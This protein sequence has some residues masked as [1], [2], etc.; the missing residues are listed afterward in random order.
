MPTTR[1]VS[2]AVL[3]AAAGTLIVP[4]AAQADDYCVNRAGC[5]P[6]NTFGPSIQAGLDAA[7]AH[8]NSGG[9]DRVLIGPGTYGVT[10]PTLTYSGDRVEVTGAGQG[11]GG[12][13][14]TGSAGDFRTLLSVTGPEP[15]R[16]SRLALEVPRGVANTGLAITGTAE[17]IAVTGGSGSTG[18]SGV[19]SATVADS[20]VQMPTE[21]SSFF[22]TVA[23]YADAQDLTVTDSVVEG[24]YGVSS[25]SGETVVQRTH[26]TGFVPVL[27]R[28]STAR[29]ES[30]V[31]EVMSSGIGVYA[32]AETR[33]MSFTVA[34]A[35]IVGAAG[36]PTGVMAL[37]AGAAGHSAY[38]SV[39]S[40]VIRDI[41]HPLR[42]STGSA[43]ASASI[44]ADY[45]DFLPA[46]NQTDGSGS[47]SIG[48]G[49][50]N[51]LTGADPGFVGER[52]VNGFKLRANSPLVDR[53][54]PFAVERQGLLDLARAPRVVDGDRT[55]GAQRDIGAFEYQPPA[56]T[57]PRPPAGTTPPGTTP[58]EPVEPARPEGFGFEVLGIKQRRKGLDLVVRVRNVGAQRR[59]VSVGGTE[60]TPAGKKR[61]V[62]RFT[63]VRRYLSPGR[64]TKVVLRVPKTLAP[65]LKRQIA[66]KGRVVRKPRI[67]VKDLASG[68]SQSFKPRLVTRKGGRR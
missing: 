12:T 11:T 21:S 46:G 63:A 32:M 7:A 1:A 16:V 54:A 56:I 59:E 23:I 26:A 42:A 28:S 34:N 65:A 5:T 62:R 64:T 67:T 35:T 60:R 53:G 2:R 8:P 19:V 10:D 33:D 41:D 6:A 61:K 27:G 43:S 9:A 47:S 29:V 58:A 36:T 40:T 39:T 15:Q 13:R 22:S 30:T 48:L 50:N 18:I 17:R 51:R 20:T 57:P 3:A 4:S 52:G 45:S 14:I 66:T 37:G 55:N 25:R 49:S 38:G 24:Q 31:I 44:Y 68:E